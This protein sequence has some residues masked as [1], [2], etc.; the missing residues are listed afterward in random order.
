MVPKALPSTFRVAAPRMDNDAPVFWISSA[1][2]GSSE[3]PPLKAIRATGISQ[4][5]AGSAT[6]G[7]TSRRPALD[8]GLEK[9]DS[10]VPISATSPES[11][12]AT[13][14]QICSMT[15]I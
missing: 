12:I 8:L 11:R 9:T 5:R 3:A 14:L 2:T 4:V 15:D 10:T 7:L 6:A 13:R 1:N